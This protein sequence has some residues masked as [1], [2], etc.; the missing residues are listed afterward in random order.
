M[1]YFVIRTDRGRH[2]IEA[3][4]HREALED[5]VEAG[6]T[7]CEVVFAGTLAGLREK[8]E[9]LGETRRLRKAMFRA[10]RKVDNDA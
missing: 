4:D 5:A 7:R 6:A 3:D 8:A 2:L 10:T 1:A 9:K